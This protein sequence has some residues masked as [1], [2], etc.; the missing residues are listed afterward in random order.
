MGEDSS[1]LIVGSKSNI[2][3]GVPSETCSSET[4]LTRDVLDG[5]TFGLFSW[6]A[7][8]FDGGEMD[9]VCI[10][11]G[12]NGGGVNCCSKIGAENIRISVTNVAKV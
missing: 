3:S 4:L 1:E 7:E 12:D 9:V 10:C 6:G 2:P 8:T 5:V 11:R